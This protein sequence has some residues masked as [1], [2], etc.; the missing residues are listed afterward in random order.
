MLKKQLSRRSFLR[1][2]GIA[3]A[4]LVA[5]LVG[6]QPKVVEKIVQQTVVVEKPVEKVV[7][8]TVVVTEQ[9]EVTKVVEKVVQETVVVEKAGAAQAALP[10]S[11]IRFGFPAWGQD[12]CNIVATNFQ[13]AQPNVEVAMEPIAEPLVDNIVKMAAG[14]TTPDTQ[15]S[16]DAYVIPFAVDKV[17][18]DMTPLAEADP[19]SPLPDIYPIMLGLGQFQNG[20]YMIAWAADAPVM[21]YNKDLFDGAGVPVPDPLGMKVNDFQLACQKISNEANQVYGTNMSYNWWA[22]Y[23]PWMVGYGGQF[24]NEDKTKVVI[25]S[26]EDIEACQALAD[27]Y[28]KYKGAVPPGANL[29]GDP[30]IVGKAATFMTNR[31]GCYSIRQANVKFNWDVCLPPIQPVK[32]T[33]GAGTMGPGVSVAAKTRGNEVAAWKLASTIATPATQKHFARLYMAIPVLMSMAKDPSWYDLP[34]PPANRDVFLEIPKR[35]IT[36]PNPKDNACG[37]VYIGD[38]NKAMNDAWDRMV[39][40]CE[41]ASKVLPEAAKIIN[42]CIARGGA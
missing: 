37:T 7:Q 23:V 2:A 11:S 8:Q 41:P 1:S 29:G 16:A 6:C 39:V 4:G 42:D 30:F 36:P 9:K 34:A 12:Y 26:P 38:T 27:L 24:Y 14:G 3:G 13:T 22:V 25:D 10:K 35:A 28:C 40:G 21:Y 20:L 15:W 33:C 17:M 32:H 31:I 18:L 19:E 5:A